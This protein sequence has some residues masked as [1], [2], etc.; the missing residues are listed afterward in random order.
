MKSQPTVPDLYR[1]IADSAHLTF[2]ADLRNQR[3]SWYK[4]RPMHFALKILGSR[5][6]SAQEDVGNALVRNRRVVVRSGNGVGKSY[7]AADLALWFLYTHS[8]AI[9]VT[10]APTKRQVKQVLWREIRHRMVTAR[11]R[12]P[13]KL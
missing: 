2:G 10:T 5:W 9:V 1:H 11:K 3:M 12:L 6:W 8:P 13:G 7:L 4:T